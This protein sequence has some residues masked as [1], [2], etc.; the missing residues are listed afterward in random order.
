MVHIEKQN[1]KKKTLEEI[2]AFGL[3]VKR[4]IFV[5]SE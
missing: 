3:K 1:L 2:V 5:V 4:K